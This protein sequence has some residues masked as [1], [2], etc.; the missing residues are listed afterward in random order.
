ML[1]AMTF[2]KETHLTYRYDEFLRPAPPYSCGLTL[3]KP[4]GWDLFTPFEIYGDGKL[5]TAAP[6]DGRLTGFLIRFSGDVMSALLRIR[7]FTERPA[8][9]NFRERIRNFLFS[10]LSLDEDLSGFYSMAEKDPILR[11]TVEK[12]Y[13]MHPTAPADIFFEAVL[14]ITLQMAPIKRSLEMMECFISGYGETAV[15][16]SRTVHVWPGADKISRISEKSLRKECRFGF[17]APYVVNSAAM[18]SSGFPSYEELAAMPPEK[19][20]D[21]LMELPGIGDYS[22]D[23]I[24]PAGGFP[25]DAWSA[26]VFGELFFGKRPENRR[27][28][29]SRIKKEGISRWGK[30]SWMAFFYIVQDLPGLSEKLGVSLRLT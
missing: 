5:W 6:V 7:V 12:L 18:I 28:Q 27:S 22:V 4:A 11:H 24:S 9:G 17:R 10:R 21:K 3:K 29:I 15:L 25:I 2:K 1:T 23:I 13:G 16:D 20:R 30:Y 14:A 19:A 8:D 26:D